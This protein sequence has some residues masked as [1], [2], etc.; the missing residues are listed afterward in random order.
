MIYPLTWTCE[1]PVGMETLCPCQ[2]YSHYEGLT[3]IRSLQLV[4]VVEISSDLVW[5]QGGHQQSP[6]VQS[7]LSNPEAAHFDMELTHRLQ[8]KLRAVQSLILGMIVDHKDFPLW[9][10]R[11]R[12]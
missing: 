1:V 2:G 9:D 10:Y 6:G 5:L 4:Q 3:E 7:L 11:C 12:C 8:Q